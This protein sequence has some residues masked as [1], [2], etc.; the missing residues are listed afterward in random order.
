M[1]SSIPIIS[2]TTQS[3]TSITTSSSKFLELPQLSLE[4]L[5]IPFANPAV[6]LL[7]SAYIDPSASLSTSTSTVSTTGGGSASVDTFPGTLFTPSHI[8]GNTSHTTAATSIITKPIPSVAAMSSLHAE[9]ASLANLATQ[10][11][12]SL[13]SN[14]VSLSEWLNRVDPHRTLRRD[15]EKDKGERRSRSVKLK[16]PTTTAGNITAPSTS[17]IATAAAVASSGGVHNDRRG[18]LSSQVLS[19]LSSSTASRSKATANGL[20]ALGSSTPSSD[21]QIKSEPYSASIY[22]PKKRS[23]ESDKPIAKSGGENGSIRLAITQNGIIKITPPVN[24][25]AAALDQTMLSSST[26]QS[27]STL[28]RTD[29]ERKLSKSHSIQKERSRRRGTSTAASVN[30]D[31]STRGTP[32]PEIRLNLDGDF[33][34]SKAPPNQVPIAQ[35]WAFFEQYYRNMTEDDLRALSQKGD[36]VTP[37]LIPPLGIHFTEQWHAEDQRIFA[38][39]E[40]GATNPSLMANREYI[41]IDEVIFEGDMMLGTLSERLMS[42]LVQEGVVPDIKF[43]DD[44]DDMGGTGTGNKVGNGPTKTF[45]SGAASALGLTGT[46]AS[47]SAAA[48]KHRARADLAV[49]EDRLRLELGFLGLIDAPD[50]EGAENVQDDEIFSELRTK[51]EELREQMAMNSRRKK[52]VHDIAEKWMG[53]QEYNGLLDEINKN[54]EQGFAK[55]LK[56]GKSR[57]GKK[58]IKDHRPVS[59]SLL[60]A[61]ESRKKLIHGVGDVFFPVDKFLPPTESIFNQL[62]P[63]DAP[64]DTALPDFA[65]ASPKS[66]SASAPALSTL[67]EDFKIPS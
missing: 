61:L 67:F 40:E 46:T 26:P 55:R 45:L 30:D 15:I 62:S 59:E 14:Q 28:I 19:G 50:S 3:Q 53:W 10:R 25:A 5:E 44:D 2:S 63:A 37:F 66:I 38:M 24:I 43:T 16:M 54:L 32:E 48:A 60:S 31:A 13:L 51:Q 8:D 47:A 33:S 21:I 4:P 11:V 6:P 64:Y 22:N 56:S 58:Q 65:N 29:R 7:Y 57:K 23:Y 36:D 1:S 52:R 18:D 49:F 39:F 35:F 17:A 34:T 9:L 42:A 12:S 41:E 27:S 20:G